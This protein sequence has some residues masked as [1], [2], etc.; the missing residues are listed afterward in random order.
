LDS[1]TIYEYA[2]MYSMCYKDNSTNINGCTQYYIGIEENY[3]N[4]LNLSVY[5]NPA[6][7]ILNVDISTSLNVTENENTEL[8][9]TDVSGRVLKQSSLDKK[10]NEINVS[11][12]ANGIYFFNLFL[13]GRFL[14]T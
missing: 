8:K 4:E 13:N 2:G 6:S 11:E 1:G 12:L 10:N 7:D 3:L 14:K 9:I 5:P